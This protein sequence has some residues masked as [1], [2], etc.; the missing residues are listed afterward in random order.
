MIVSGRAHV[1]IGTEGEGKAEVEDGGDG[2]DGVRAGIKGGRR[3]NCF[4]DHRW[5]DVDIYTGSERCV[6]VGVKAGDGVKQAGGCRRSELVPSI[7]I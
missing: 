7:N 1:I 3:G 2:C 5:R 6:T 4:K